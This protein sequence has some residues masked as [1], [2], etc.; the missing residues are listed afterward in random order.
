MLRILAAICLALLVH[1]SSGAPSPTEISAWASQLSS[2]LTTLADD[3]LC[4]STFQNS[5]TAQPDINI[6]I[7]GGQLTE[8][9][10]TRLVARF[11]RAQ[12]SATAMRDKAQRLQSG[13]EAAPAGGDTRPLCCAVNLD[14]QPIDW[15]FQQVLSSNLLL[16]YRYSSFGVP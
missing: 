8:Q 3:V 1:S 2:E 4:H 5:L 9:V 13:A 10:A 6:T 16:S 15:K 14:D 12:A 11:T 7:D